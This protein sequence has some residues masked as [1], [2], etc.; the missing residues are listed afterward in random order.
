MVRKHVFIY[1]LLAWAAAFLPTLANAAT[2]TIGVSEDGGAIACPGPNCFTG[3]SNF[4]ISG[5]ATTNFVVNAGGTTQTTLPSPGLL[6]SNNLS[7]SNPNT[8][9]ASHFLDVFVTAQGLTDPLGN[10]LSP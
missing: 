6:F 1:A 2:I 5:F 4:N 7:V 10:P 9:G 3:G 8:D